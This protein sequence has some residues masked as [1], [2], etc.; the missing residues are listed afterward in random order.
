[1]CVCLCL[2]SLNG[3]LWK[4]PSPFVTCEEMQ[5]ITRWP[6]SQN[7]KARNAHQLRTQHVASTRC[8]TLFRCFQNFYSFFPFFLSFFL[9]SPP[10]WL[11]VHLQRIPMATLPSCVLSQRSNQIVYVCVFCCYD[12]MD[13]AGGSSVALTVISP[14]YG[15]SNGSG[16]PSHYNSPYAMPSLHPSSSPLGPQAPPPPPPPPIMTTSTTPTSRGLHHQPSMRGGITSPQPV[17]VC[18]HFEMDFLFVLFFLFLPFV[19]FFPFVFLRVVK[20]GTFL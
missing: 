11:T 17:G 8:V 4:Y 5:R 6:T 16:I 15:S 18:A 10:H 20:I 13:E 2:R 14:A 12:F 7:L 19:P 1:M 3:T 9:S